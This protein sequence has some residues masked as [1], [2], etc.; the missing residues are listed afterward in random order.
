MQQVASTK[1][2]WSMIED[3]IT[4]TDYSMLQQDSHVISW[5]VCTVDISCQL[6]SVQHFNAEFSV[7]YYRATLRTQYD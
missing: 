4:G 5:H 3:D 6:K 2:A 7:L 1:T